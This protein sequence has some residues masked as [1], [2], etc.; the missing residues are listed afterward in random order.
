MKLEQPL[1]DAPFGAP[2]LP[3]V[4]VPRELPSALC[5]NKGA[6][7]SEGRRDISTSLTRIVCMATKGFRCRKSPL[8]KQAQPVHPLDIETGESGG[9]YLGSVRSS[10]QYGG[11][12]RRV[13]PLKRPCL[14]GMGACGREEE[15]QYFC[16]SHP[17]PCVS[18]IG[19]TGSLSICSARRRQECIPSLSLYLTRTWLL[20]RWRGFEQL[21]V[22]LPT[23]FRRA[24]CHRD[25]RRSLSLL[26]FATP[27]ATFTLCK[28]GSQL[29]SGSLS[30]RCTGASGRR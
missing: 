29:G 6:A 3:V 12:R 7:G 2:K 26:V 22:P 18:C 9:E 10:Q 19:C 23:S 8:D 11:A 13:R 16:A 28:D 27:L 15:H 30:G 21:R 17:L 24:K 25:G 5:L 20:S 14:E 1:L 4:I